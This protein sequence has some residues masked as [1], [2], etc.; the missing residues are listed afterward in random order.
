MSSYFDMIKDGVIA[1]NGSK[2]KNALALPIPDYSK[3]PTTFLRTGDLSLDYALGGGVIVG[4]GLTEI[5][6][7][8]SYGKTMISMMIAA[9]TIHTFEKGVVYVDTEGG[10]DPRWAASLGVNFDENSVY[11]RPNDGTEAYQ[12]IT[13][14]MENAESH[15]TKLV[16]L[17]SMAFMFPREQM[18][19]TDLSSR[20]MS[21]ATMNQEFLQRIP[22]LMRPQTEYDEGGPA[23]GVAFIAINQV[24]VD[25]DAGQYGDGYKA[26]GGNAKEHAAFQQVKVMAPEAFYRKG[27]DKIKN[28]V[29]PVFR[30]HKG[31]VHKNKVA[32]SPREFE[33]RMG[34]R[35]GVVH[36]RGYS[37][38]Q[39]ARDLQLLTNAGGEPYGNAGKVLFKGIEI[40]ST[41]AAAEDALYYDD[42]MYGELCEAVWSE[43]E[44][45]RIGGGSHTVDEDD[46]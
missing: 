19:R 3:I 40:G 45:R 38:F 28:K 31:R 5:W 2:T 13:W 37:A 23:R 18:E 20:M 9:N 6:G 44:V 22:R 41:R 25:M 21:Q 15:G 42:D 39:T 8:K 46:M 1:Y 27:E 10:L 43:I 14:I 4:R 30:T 34:S 29:A 26:P 12:F 17:D 11:Y 7:A 16:I 35:D 33:F 36:M 24:R 32:T